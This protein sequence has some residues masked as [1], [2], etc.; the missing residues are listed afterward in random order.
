MK[1]QFVFSMM[2]A[3]A[4]LLAACNSND[5]VKGESPY[6]PTGEGYVS[7]NIMLPT[8][9]T[10]NTRANDEWQ[11]GLTTEYQVNDAILVIFA[12]TSENTA[13]FQS[14]Y[15]LDASP[16]ALV[17]SAT[18]GCTT[19]A[20]LTAL[21]QQKEEQNTD[22]IYAYVILNGAGFFEPTTDNALQIKK[23]VK[24]ADGTVSEGAYTTIYATDNVSFADFTKYELVA[25][26]IGAPGAMLMTSAPNS[27][28]QGGVDDPA[29]A[30]AKV[31]AL[32]VLDKKKI[33]NTSEMAKSN[34][35]ADVYVGR[36][37]VKVEVTTNFTTN[38]IVGNNAITFD[39]ASFRWTLGNTNKTFY[40][41]RQFDDNWL[42]L[43]AQG[44]TEAAPAANF[45]YRF[46]GYTEIH[47]GVWRTYWGVDPNYDVD[48]FVTDTEGNLVHGGMFDNEVPAAAAFAKKATEVMYT[49]ENTMNENL[50][51]HWNTTYVAIAVTLNGGNPFYTVPNTTGDDVIYATDDDIKNYVKSIIGTLPAYEAFLTANGFTTTLD[52]VDVTLDTTDPSDVAVTI[53]LK[54]GVTATGFAAVATAYATA[55]ADSPIYFYAGGVSYYYVPIQH[56]SNDE[57]PWNPSTKAS[58]EYD[59]TYPDNAAPDTREA[60]YLGRY[61]VLRNNWYKLDVTGIRHIGKP[62]PV[63][64][65]PEP[66]D[67]VESTS[68]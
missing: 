68:A 66:D 55:M 19:E 35:A 53:A 7:F 58:Q 63:E 42:G 67:E 31:T 49:T 56:F 10:T 26:R 37:A 20:R 40:V 57:T 65:S 45:K 64:P 32:A 9:P 62:E 2:A 1:K 33:F 21:L 41:G 44:L 51:K 25:S 6:G 61:G 50:M 38:T 39:A 15:N 43:F 5:G 22:Q 34:P 52:D 54:E 28:K 23:A 47:T 11:D 36:S 17:G 3:A 27:D 12:G 13:T 60:N 16:F 29:S 46:V 59:D 30:G 24:A 18:D 14:A 48:N 8:S 4:F